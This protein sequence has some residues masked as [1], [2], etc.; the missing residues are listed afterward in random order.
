MIDAKIRMFA[1]KIVGELQQD[2][3]LATINKFNTLYRY[4]GYPEGEE[5][6]LYLQKKLDEYGID[7][8]MYEYEAFLGLPLEASV[9]VTSPEKFTIK[10]IGDVFSGAA[11]NLEGKLYY[12]VYSEKANLTDLEQQERLAACKGKIV[13]SRGKADFINKAYLAGALAVLHISITKGGY[14]HHCGIGTI[15]GNPASEDISKHTFAPTAGISW[16][17]GAKL[18]ELLRKGSVSVKLNIKMDNTI[19]RSHM[20]VAFIKGASSKYILIS[21]HYDS[22]Y[23]GITDNAVSDAIALELARVLQ[24]HKKELKRSVK[25]CWWSGHSD[26]RYAG[27]AWF[28]DKEW[29]DLQENCMG[30]INMDLTGCKLAKQIRSRTT[31]MEGINFTSDLIAEF[32][33]NR[34][35]EYIPMIRGADQSFLGV[36]VPI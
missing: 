32:T 34:P 3:M 15:W 5:A 23:E 20:P 24:E 30:H 21:C 22:W 28:C 13:L 16:E 27:S 10:A 11:K 18:C 36:D 4:T 35:T 2:N 12:D 17:D 26:G 9:E 6:A 31:L 7:N 14:I 19:R 25:I 1:D 8:K 29:V 33:G